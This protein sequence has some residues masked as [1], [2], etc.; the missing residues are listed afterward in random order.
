MYGFNNNNE[1][2]EIWGILALTY[3][4]TNEMSSLYTNMGGGGVH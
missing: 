2:E 4:S 3:L 1:E